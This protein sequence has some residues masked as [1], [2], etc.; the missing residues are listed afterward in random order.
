[1][2]GLRV[3]V[4][5]GAGFIGR[6]LVEVLI[7]DPNVELIRVMDDLSNGYFENVQPFLDHP[8]YEFIQASITNYEACIDATKNIDFVSHQAALGSVPRSIENPMLTSEVNIMGT[9]NILHACVQNGIRKIVLAC[10]SSTYGDNSDLP[11]VENRIGSPLS[12]Y[13]VTKLCVEQFA[14]V[15]FKNYGLNY[16]GLRYFNVFGPWQNP[17]NPYAAVI[18]LFCR[19]FIENKPPVIF[20]DGTVSRDFTYVDNVVFANLLAMFNE[21]ERSNN[22][23]YNV[24][25]NQSISLNELVRELRNISG[26]ILEPEYKTQRKGEILHSLADI[27]KIGDVLGYYPKINFK[28]GLEKTYQW[29]LNT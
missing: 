7:Q 28:E 1:M 4:T 25:C 24:A 26:K 12:P 5:G 3:L 22:T 17:N 2:A 20:G 27:S 14:E 16:I 29:Y 11:K 18:P 19:A 9:L 8:K 10:S 13:A 15:F 6:N 23:I 21:N